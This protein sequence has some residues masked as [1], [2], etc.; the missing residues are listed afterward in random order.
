V[1]T[2]LRE[3]IDQGI[4]TADEQL[5]SESQLVESFDVSRITIRRALQTLEGEGMIYRRQG[6]GSF[7]RGDRVSQG[8]VRLTDFAEDMAAAGLEPSSV[9]IH[10]G[11]DEARG[12]VAEELA[13]EEGHRVIRLDRVRL[14]DG[15]PIAFDRT[16]LTA[17]YSQLLEGRD[18]TKE[19]IYSILEQEYRIPV[20]RGKFRI[21]A[22]NAPADIGQHLSVPW[23]RA[24]LLIERT[25]CTEAGRTVYYQQ[26]YYRSDRVAYDLELR[27]SPGELSRTGGLPMREFEAVFKKSPDFTE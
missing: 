9:L 10:H 8:L 11:G 7:V 20:V 23:G 13:V 14:A 1:S 19:T 3:Q 25:S 18:L 6:L 16:W 24:L 27:R 26:R 2:W 4:Y 12:R 17:F 21:E 15:E 22:V 5:P